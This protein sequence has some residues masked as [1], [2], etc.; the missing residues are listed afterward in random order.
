MKRDIT[1]VLFD[2]DDT[3]FDRQRAQHAIIESFI[4]TLPQ[5]SH[6]IGRQ[7]VISAFFESDRRALEAYHVGYPIREFRDRR[8]EIF[9]ATLGLDTGL[10]G[11][12]SRMYVSI[13]ETLDT[14]VDG[15]VSVVDELSRSYSLGIVSNGFP[16]I[17]GKKVESIG[18][19]GHISCMV[20]SEVLG[21]A[22]PDTAIFEY[23]LTVLGAEPSESL[24][25]G[26]SFENDV[27]GAKGAGMMACWF[28]PRHRPPPRRD[29]LPDIAIARLDEIP[30]F[31]MAGAAGR[32]GRQV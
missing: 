22:K 16:D 13:Y 8:S 28:N 27:V 29:I 12:L 4:E 14:P 32:D 21:V 6:G 19:K 20:L 31:L 17:Q 10:A 7:D 2:L 25:V 5:L 15:A 3:L 18:L 24:Y 1:T 30:E 26:D 9:L 23:A 11:E